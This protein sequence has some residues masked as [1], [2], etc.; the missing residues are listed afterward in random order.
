M[1]QVLQ[2]YKQMYVST[3]ED[4]EVQP[5]VLFE[6]LPDG[7]GY[8]FIKNFIISPIWQYV[9]DGKITHRT[10]S[11]TFFPLMYD[12]RTH[13]LI[14][15]ERNKKH[16]DIYRKAKG[17][18]GQ[19]MFAVRLDTFLN[20][21]Y[22]AIYTIPQSEFRGHL[23]NQ[24]DRILRE[25]ASDGYH[26]STGTS[27]ETVSFLKRYQTQTKMHESALLRSINTSRYIYTCEFDNPAEQRSYDL[28]ELCFD[29]IRIGIQGHP[30]IQSAFIK[31]T[32]TSEETIE[33]LTKYL[34]EHMSEKVSITNIT[35]V[36]SHHQFVFS[37]LIEEDDLPA[38]GVLIAV[39]GYFL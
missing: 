24:Y 14:E 18:S 12:I 28:V 7:L 26:Q 2:G 10:R 17:L 36:D 16:Y 9:E 37:F 35:L 8:P 33:H 3:A 11:G 39:E 27:P 32:Y 38:E 21:I 1:G 25:A 34:N 30:F 20:D 13:R 4:V 19:E 6:L 31:N 5:I 23:V 29:A 15:T 22:K